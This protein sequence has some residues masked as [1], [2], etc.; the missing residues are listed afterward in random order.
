[1]K[2][3]VAFSLLI[4]SFIN[5]PAQTPTGKWKKISHTSVY[6]GTKFDS[7]EALL[8]SR[9]CAA[10]II[11]EVNADGTFRLNAA[12]SGCDASYSKVQEK[13]YSKTLWKVDGNK[14]TTSTQTD[15][16][17]GQTYTIS[18]SAKRMIWVGTDGQGTITYEKL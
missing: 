1:M 16:S 11:Y 3:L 6:N 8:K 2:L 13:L 15:F 7:H 12:S 5:A 10:K 18:Y 17:I 14:I 4:F 9:P